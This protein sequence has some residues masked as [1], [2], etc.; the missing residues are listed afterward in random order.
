MTTSKN[1]S[2]TP[3]YD[4]PR[5]EGDKVTFSTGYPQCYPQLILV[6]IHRLST[7][8]HGPNRFNTVMTTLNQTS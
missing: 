3:P 7:G 6:V 4:V 5:V 8:S 2:D 1:L